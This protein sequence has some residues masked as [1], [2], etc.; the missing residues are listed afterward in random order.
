MMAKQ[1]K[2]DKMKKKKSHA[3]VLKKIV[4]NG[5]FV[6]RY[7]EEREIDC[8][9]YKKIISFFLHIIMQPRAE[10]EKLPSRRSNAWCTM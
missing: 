1:K 4:N 2:V 5:N 6:N 9:V 10:K 8:E 3:M 7:S